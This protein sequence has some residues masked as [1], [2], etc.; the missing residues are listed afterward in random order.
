MKIKK[1]KKTIFQIMLATA[2]FIVLSSF[3]FQNQK[4]IDK[5]TQPNTLTKKE[6]KEGWNLL[7]DGKTSNGWRG[8]FKDKFPEKGWQIKD[9]ILTV[10]SSTGAE[11]ANGGDIVTIDEYS[12][13]ELKVDFKITPGANSGIKYF[14]TE[15]EGAHQGSALGL[16]YQ[17]LDDERHPD[18]KLGRDGDR[19][20]ASLYD[21]IPAQNKK[22]NPIGEWNHAKIISNGKHVEHW[23]NDTKVVE[24]ERGSESFMKLIAISKYKDKQGFGLAEKGHILLQDHGNEVSFRNIKIKILTNSD[25]K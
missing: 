20:I 21:L 8:V 15:S 2:G 25:K 24:Y 16:E 12:N 14:V 1:T 23:L 17:I 18:A 11:S 9:G 4:N 3:L 5:E 6:I 13:F 19:T 22:P 7:F 10:L